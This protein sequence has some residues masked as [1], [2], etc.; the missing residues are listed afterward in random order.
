MDGWKVGMKRWMDGWDALGYVMCIATCCLPCKCV[1]Y[2][3]VPAP[4]A[5]RYVS[6]LVQCTPSNY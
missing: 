6:S 1:L 4:W 3:A 2:S 5:G